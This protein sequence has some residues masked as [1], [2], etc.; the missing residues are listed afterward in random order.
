VARGPIG[1]CRLP[2]VDVDPHI[3]GRF[4]LR[5]PLALATAL[6]AAACGSSPRSSPGDDAGGDEAGNDRGPDATTT[7]ADGGVEAA[8]D[9]DAASSVV[10]DGSMASEEAGSAA[11]DAMVSSDG[12]AVL[13]DAGASTGDAAI[14]PDAGHA[15][16]AGPDGASDAGLGADALP[17][18]VGIKTN[19][20]PTGPATVQGW[21]DRPLDIAGTTITTTSYIGGGDTYENAT[22]SPLPLLEVSFPL[23]SI[24][25]EDNDLDDLSKAATGAYD[26]TYEAMSMALAAWPNTLVGARIGWEFNG[27]WYAW[28]D[29]VGT[30][31]TYANYVSAFQHAAKAIR[32]YN[33]DAL[34]EWCVAWGQADPTPYWPG[35]YD[36]STNAGGVDVISMDFYQANISQ[37]NSGGNQSTWA[38]AQSSGTINL[39]WMVT[40]A[41]TNGVKIALS[42]YAAGAPGSGGEGSGAGLDDGTWTTAAIAWVNSQPAGFF[43]WTMWSDDAP[44]DDIVTP[45][46]N[47]AEQTAWKA[48][49]KGTHF[50]GTWWP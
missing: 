42:E 14:H 9:D 4:G 49:W 2:A 50:G 5:P 21:L 34:I 22:G 40:Y 10:D 26:S 27:T 31:A 47:P 39:D 38:M 8:P 13:V 3:I 11:G 33:P 46:A 41:Q 44:A 7:E 15:S 16:D 6:F 30:N 48:A 17:Y 24:F 18:M 25:G 36:A 1:R 29:G 43:L 19:G 45:G 20:D 23:L 32:K 37:Y 28:S 12:G 35:V